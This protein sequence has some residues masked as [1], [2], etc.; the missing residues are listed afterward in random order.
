MDRA[1]KP[2]LHRADRIHQLFDQG[3]GKKCRNLGQ[4][5]GDDGQSVV[6]I[7]GIMPMNANA[8]VLEIQ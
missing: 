5:W 2:D 1:Q 7:L 4:S 8:V 6:I 3:W